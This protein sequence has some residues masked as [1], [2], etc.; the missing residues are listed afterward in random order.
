MVEVLP[1]QK[2]EMKLAKSL[3]KFIFLR[4]MLSLHLKEK[5][6]NFISVD[7]H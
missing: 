6:N 3:I 1:T 5:I 7:L 4:L 2:G